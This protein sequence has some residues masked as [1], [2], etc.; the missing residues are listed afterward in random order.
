M[1]NS[2]FCIACI[3]LAQDS[4]QGLQCCLYGFHQ[5]TFA[6]FG[7]PGKWSLLVK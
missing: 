2:Y 4:I 6:H 7:A 1:L 3:L 5:I